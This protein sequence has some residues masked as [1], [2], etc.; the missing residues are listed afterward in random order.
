MEKI[1]LYID[2]NNKLTLDIFRK[3]E[4]EFYVKRVK[5]K[6]CYPYIK[7]LCETPIL[8]THKKNTDEELL[9]EFSRYIINVSEPSKVLE[10]RGTAIL[11]DNI[12]NYETKK[13]RAKVK[14]KKVKRVNKHIGKRIIA[15][16]LL[17]L[18]LLSSIPI[19][20]VILNKWRKRYPEKDPYQI[21]QQIKKEALD[22]L[23]K[24]NEGNPI[25]SENIQ[26][27]GEIFLSISYDDRS[28]TEKAIRAELNY[29][30]ML[31]KYSAIYG[32]NPEVML[33]IAT[34]ERGIHSEIKDKGGA[35]G[36]MQIQNSVWRG[37]TITV[38]NYQL[39]KKRVYNSR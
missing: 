31:R 35:T 6:D 34:Q 11:R 4:D 3:K 32:I 8:S 14:P 27:S 30:E 10:R 28:N 19:I 5:G 39:G 37:E 23:N 16:F 1:E 38:D 7:Q 21:E 17:L 13:N 25:E 9:V 36:L 12:A 26:E 29:G 24:K 22:E 33:A 18:M 20:S 15:G 2:N